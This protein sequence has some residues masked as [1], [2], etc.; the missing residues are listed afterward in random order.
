MYETY[1]MTVKRCVERFTIV[2]PAVLSDEAKRD[3][4]DFANTLLA[5]CQTDFDGSHKGAIANRMNAVKKLLS[6][7]TVD[8]PLST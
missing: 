6:L 5:Q 2:C 1:P 7:V 3:V 8:V 4:L